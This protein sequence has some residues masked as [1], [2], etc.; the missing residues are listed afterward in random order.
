MTRDLVLVTLF[1]ARPKTMTLRISK[2]RVCENDQDKKDMGKGESRLTKVN[3][4]G[5]GDC[6]SRVVLFSATEYSN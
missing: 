5:K 2:G 3:R 4:I 1:Q 6:D